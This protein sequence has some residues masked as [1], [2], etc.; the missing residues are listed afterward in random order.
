MPAKLLIQFG[1]VTPSV[2]YGNILN[3]GYIPA[4]LPAQL[5]CGSSMFMLMV[6]GIPTNSS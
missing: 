6:D 5:C 4:L 1:W 2:I 3:D